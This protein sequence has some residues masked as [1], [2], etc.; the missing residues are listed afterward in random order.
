[1]RILITG[2]EGFIGRA[3]VQRLLTLG[4]PAQ[5]SSEPLEL[6]LVDRNFS[7]APTD[8]RVTARQG[9]LA[10]SALLEQAVGAGVEC[11][12]HLASVTGG[13]AEADFELG[14]RANL[15]ATLA[16]LEV[17]RRQKS[18]ARLVFASTIGVYGVP[19]P[20]RIDESAI[21]A[22][23]LSYGAQKLM[24]E[25][26]VTDYSRRGFV[27]GR[28]LRLPGIVARPSGSGMLSGFLSEIIRVLSA[29]GRFICPVAE[30]GKS[31]WMSR[32][33]AVD[34]LLHAA[35]LGSDLVQAR[36]VFL[37]PVLHAS[38]GDVV[39][40]IARIHG[41]EVRARVSYQPNAALQAQFASYPP[42]SCPGS[43]AAGFRHDGSLEALVQRALEGPGAGDRL[44]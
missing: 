23:T 18:Q 2:A 9:D 29:G 20:Q 3:L 10:D 19:L 41:P 30:Q 15:H 34:N 21:P 6:V 36:R 13:A 40:A 22:P 17:L 37:L 14:M 8:P 38:V 39:S 16:L 43:E 25:I 5:L 7:S 11:V 4:A 12:F 27:D 31:W 32:T 44:A 35:A 28:S 24:G 1:M 33:C 26:L 42:L